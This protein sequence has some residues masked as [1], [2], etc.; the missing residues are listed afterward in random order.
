[1]FAPRTRGLFD[2]FAA[3]T[4]LWAAAY[5]TPPGALVRGAVAK[6]LSQKNTARPLLAYYSGGVYDAQVIDTPQEVVDLPQPS[7]LAAVP[8]GPAI[9][10]GVFATLKK[11]GSDQKNSSAALARRYS[12]DLARLDDPSQGPELY[13]VLIAK[14]QTDLGSEDAAVLAAFAG[15]PA[16][17][18]A[19]QRAKA[20]HRAL[21]LEV[22]AQQLPPSE[23]GAID[24]ASQ[25]LTL[26]SA[27]ALGWPVPSRTRVSSPFGLRTH[28]TLGTQKMHTGIDLALVEGSEVRASAGGTVRR[29]SED[30][31]NG[32]VVIIDHGRGI[33]TAYCHN[34]RLLVATGQVVKAGDVISESGNTG[35]STGPHLHYQ[36]ELAHTPMDPFLFKSANSVDQ[37]VLGAAKLPVPPKPI[38]PTVPAP[39]PPAPKKPNPKLLD[40]F[41]AATAPAVLDAGVHE[42]PAPA[43]ESPTNATE[44]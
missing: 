8:Q 39:A 12:V 13:G 5:H 33:S 26:G 2:F 3:V 28:P 34:S 36:L 31:V 40:A 7:L 35:R 43:P 21:S 19:V 15:Y 41:K 42:P 23:R 29:A 32:K 6:V 16:A 44:F 4:C 38:V 24:A 25:A 18:F 27:Y 14:A 17:D 11:S 10:R 37:L 1:M 9:G 22:L 20:E 30:G